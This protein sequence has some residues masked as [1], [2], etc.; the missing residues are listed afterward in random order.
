MAVSTFD[1]GKDILKEIGKARKQLDKQLAR[2]EKWCKENI[3]ENFRIDVLTTPPSM[4][5][6]YTTTDALTRIVEG[7]QPVSAATIKEVFSAIEK[8]YEIPNEGNKK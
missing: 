2:F 8:N 6:L 1:K 3:S 5:N 4:D 7:T